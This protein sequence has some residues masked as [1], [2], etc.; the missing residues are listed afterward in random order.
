M[1]LWKHIICKHLKWFWLA[2]SYAV[3]IVGYACD[4]FCSIYIPS[5]V[6]QPELGTFLRCLPLA[7]RNS[8]RSFQMLGWKNRSSFRT[9]NV[10]VGCSHTPSLSTSSIIQMIQYELVRLLDYYVGDKGWSFLSHDYL[11]SMS[12]SVERGV[13]GHPF[14]FHSA[15]TRHILFKGVNTIIVSVARGR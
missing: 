1:Y 6:A 2:C 15:F 3:L 7:M 10:M 4:E 5:T 9:L 8:N 12:L 13:G 14:N 11:N